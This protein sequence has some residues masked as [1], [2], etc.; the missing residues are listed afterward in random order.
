M[1][2]GVT[3]RVDLETVV[4]VVVVGVGVV[5]VVVFRVTERIIIIIEIDGDVVHARWLDEGSQIYV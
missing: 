2:N 5:G 3:E 1:V 4:H